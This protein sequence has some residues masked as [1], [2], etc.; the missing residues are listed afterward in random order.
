MLHCE[1]KPYKCDQ[2]DKTFTQNCHLIRHVMIHSGEKPFKCDQ[3]DQALANN[4]NLIRNVRTHT[5]EKLFE[6]SD[7]SFLTKSD[8]NTHW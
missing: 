7:N 6:C 3:Y 8:E 4:Y 5:G 1:D 2:C